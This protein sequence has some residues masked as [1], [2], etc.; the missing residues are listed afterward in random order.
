MS[1]GAPPARDMS[2]YNNHSGDQKPPKRPK[3]G[4]IWPLVLFAVGILVV[5]PVGA[6]FATSYLANNSELV[7]T[8]KQL[9]KT[10]TNS[11]EL[12]GIAYGPAKDEEQRE[13]RRT[14]NGLGL[15]LT[16]GTISDQEAE[17]FS[18][19][20]GMQEMAETQMKAM[21][22]DALKEKAKELYGVD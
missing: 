4:G 8:A 2:D 15:R 21:N 12:M 14:M 20:E 3:G 22:M 19:P 9:T 11:V 7:T 10:A 5:L 18:T 6:F 13:A 16:A 17:Y 1:S